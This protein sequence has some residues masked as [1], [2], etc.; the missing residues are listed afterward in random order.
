MLKLFAPFGPQNMRPVFVSRNLQVVGSP[1]IVGRN[2][3]KFK[4]RQHKKVF[5]VIGFNMGDLFYRIGPGESHLDL[6]YV[7]EENEYMGRK[8]VQL[9]AKDL[10]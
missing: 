2:H 3:L 7:I 5:D 4:V 1:S 6:A 10:R 9:R 8:T